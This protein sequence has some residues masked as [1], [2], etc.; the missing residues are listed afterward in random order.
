V[1]Q[2]LRLHGHIALATLIVAGTVGCDSGGG[3]GNPSVQEEAGTGG[4]G[5]SENPGDSSSGSSSGVSSGSSSG[6][7]SVSGSSDPGTCSQDPSVAC[8]VG[9]GYSCTGS[10]T[11]QGNNSLNCG[12]SV[13]INVGL[14]GYC[15]TTIEAGPPPAD[16]SG[17]CAMDSTIMCSSGT[18][19]YFCTGN[20]E[21]TSRISGVTTCSQGTPEGFGSVR[22]DY[23]CM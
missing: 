23:C 19:G 2:A 7:P 10:A 14:I 6:S 4:S 15:C 5:S 21:P 20:A 18:T 22:T 16:M 17:M 13:P 12:G 3:S 11:L 9:D 1:I 8:T